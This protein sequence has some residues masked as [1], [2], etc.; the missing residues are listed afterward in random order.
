MKLSISLRNSIVRAV[1]ADVPRV[2]YDDQI[3]ELARQHAIKGLPPAVAKVYA[4]PDL[5]AYLS[6]TPATVGSRPY[7]CYVI[8]PS[9][10][11]EFVKHMEGIDDAVSALISKDNAQRQVL[12]E[13]RLKVRAAVYAHTT[14]KSLLKAYPEWEKY[15]PQDPSAVRTPNLPAPANLISDLVK[16]GWPDG[17][18]PK[19][20]AKGEEVAA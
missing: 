1:M 15:I 3:R 20:E 6:L 7:T 16:L 10:G 17:G 2:D 9:S 12:H 8:G 14:T 19:A 18:K 11:A 13:M 5:R 4:D